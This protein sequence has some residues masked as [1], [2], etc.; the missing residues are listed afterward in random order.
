MIEVVVIFVAGIIG[1]ASHCI[2]MCGPFTVAIGVSASPSHSPWMVQLFYSFGRLFTYVFLGMAAGL[3]GQRLMEVT[4]GFINVPAALALLAGALLIYQGLKSAGFDTLKWVK[5]KSGL[6][7]QA[8][9]KAAGSTCLAGSFFGPLLRSKNLS[10]IFIAGLFTGLLPCGLVY[11]FLARAVSA[12]DLFQGGLVMLVF[13]LGTFPVM[14][15]T[16]VGVTR[17]GLRS[18]EILFRVAAWSLVATGIISITRGAWFLNL[19]SEAAQATCPF[20]L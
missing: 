16:G 6:F 20:C 19:G 14:I 13:G 7:A 9:A 15:I 3:G 11:G 2:G 4:P 8:P 10:G 5:A 12:T 18:R 17:I 1:S